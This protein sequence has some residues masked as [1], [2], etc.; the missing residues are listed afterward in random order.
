VTEGTLDVGDAWRSLTLHE[1]RFWLN[2]RLEQDVRVEIFVVGTG[3]EA[4]PVVTATGRLLHGR[5]RFS[6]AL[7]ADPSAVAALYAIGGSETS[8]NLS[9][10]P[11]DTR[12]FADDSRIGVELAD[13]VW[14]RVT[15]ITGALA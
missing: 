12:A 1:V 13:G 11:D 6:L 2:D 14:L 4:H 10:L 9:L 15:Q 3:D 5:Q 8:F 7:D